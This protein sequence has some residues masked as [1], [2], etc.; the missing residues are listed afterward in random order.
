[1]NKKPSASLW[2][3]FGAWVKERREVKR[4][5]QGKAASLAGIDRQ[6]WYRIEKGKS[7]TKRDT[8]IAIAKALESDEADALAKAGFSAEDPKWKPRNTIELL[9][10]LERLGI[11]VD[12]V[13]PFDL[14]P[15]DFSNL[16]NDIRLVVELRAR[17]EN[18]K[19][20]QSKQHYSGS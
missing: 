16:L 6:Q 13:E 9:E 19:P 15:D 5:T 20:R 4:L 18:E 12:H 14:S 17:R 1:M 10:A 3:D 11:D 7:G 8:V 2:E